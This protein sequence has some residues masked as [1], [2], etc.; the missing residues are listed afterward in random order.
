MSH[1]K[2]LL[3]WLLVFSPISAENSVKLILTNGEV[4]IGEII[5][6]KAEGDLDYNLGLICLV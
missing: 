2:Y 5:S 3:A 1:I 4:L 6:F